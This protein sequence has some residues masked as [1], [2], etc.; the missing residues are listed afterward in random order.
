MDEVC[1]TNHLVSVL[2]MKS[3]GQ[4]SVSIT[5]T[6]YCAYSN[7]ICTKYDVEANFSNLQK[8]KHTGVILQ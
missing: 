7:L 6:M 5:S 4:F 8:I 1:L 2:M 3:N